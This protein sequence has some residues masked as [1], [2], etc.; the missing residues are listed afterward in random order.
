MLEIM[1][2]S[3]SSN[4]K[5]FEKNINAN[6]VPKLHHSNTNLQISVKVFGCH[7]PTICTME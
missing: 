6:T 2:K 4:F 3:E 7:L 5:Y 1:P